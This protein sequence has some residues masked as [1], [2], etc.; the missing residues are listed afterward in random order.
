MYL[1]NNIY[2]LKRFFFITLNGTLFDILLHTRWVIKMS[3]RYYKKKKTYLPVTLGC[4]AMD[5][6]N[7][8]IIILLINISL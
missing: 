3:I 7:I 2:T 1:Y 6:P 4:L 5:T 8:N